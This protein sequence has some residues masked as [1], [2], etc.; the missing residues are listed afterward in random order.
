MDEKRV[1]SLF[2]QGLDTIVC[3]IYESEQKFIA[4][5][6]LFKEL[7]IPEK[8]YVLR[9]RYFRRDKDGEVALDDFGI[10]LSN[11]GGMME[12]AEYSIPA[13]RKSLKSPCH[14]PFY[15]IMIDF[16]G[17]YLICTHDWAKNE[18]LGNVKDKINQFNIVRNFLKKAD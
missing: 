16:N 18:V 7:E 17:D 6:N 3:S 11:R 13:L 14:Y 15:A 5:K 4:V 1:L 12:N 9:K 8:R 2:D 10:N